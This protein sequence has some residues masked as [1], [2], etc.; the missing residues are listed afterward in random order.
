MKEDNMTSMDSNFNFLC[1][2]P[3]GAGPPAHM[4][5][6]EPDLLPLR[7]DVISG[8]PLSRKSLGFWKKVFRFLGL[9][10]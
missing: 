10:S 7:V 1:G 5:P 8:W 3:N 2:R 6:P 4:R 9:V